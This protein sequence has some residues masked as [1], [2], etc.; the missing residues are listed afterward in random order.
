MNVM[1]EIESHPRFLIVSL[2]SIGLRHL[3]NLRILRPQSQIAALRLLAGSEASLPAG[4]DIQLRTMTDVKAFAPSA[5]IIAGPASTHR[6]IAFELISMGVPVMVEKPFANSLNGLTEIVQTARK[7]KVP[8][9]VGYNLRFKPSLV[10]ARRR[11]LSGVFGNILSVRA[12]VGQY[13]PDW[14]PGSDYR[15]SVSAQQ[16]LGGGVL[17]ELSHEI[18]YLY[19]FFGLPQR[20]SCRG[21]HLSGLD[22][23]VEDTVELCLEY[24]HPKRMVSIHLD[25]IQRNVSRSCKFI[26]TLGTLIWDGVDDRIDMF[27][28]EPSPA[29]SSDKFDT[30]DRNSMYLD[31][32]AHFLQCVETGSEPL[33]DG[34]QAY[35]VM[36]IVEAAKISMQTK[37]IQNLSSYVQIK[38]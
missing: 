13:L 17:L 36:I 10:E 27:V 35:E 2:G 1:V 25:F 21:G 14:R 8:L 37:S 12:E 28:A 16:S 23:D 3:R 30:T 9:M 38:A 4:C 22:I 18:D 19:W 6:E 33:I 34:V 20:V 32:L 15:K 5:A 29:S 24:D 26:G 11:I 31:E 7:N